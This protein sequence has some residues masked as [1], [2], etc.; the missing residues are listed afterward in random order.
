MLEY[1]NEIIEM[2][3]KLTS[4]ISEKK[5]SEFNELFNQRIVEGWELEAHTYIGDQSAATNLMFITFKAV[6]NTASLVEY[7]CETVEIPAKLINKAIGEKDLAKF[8]DLLSQNIADGWELV[9]HTFLS[10]GGGQ[11]N[12]MF[13]TFKK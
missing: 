12:I 9:S 13:I 6:Q 11:P 7:K 5:V 4:L 1:K 10:A 2:P 3:V 8:N